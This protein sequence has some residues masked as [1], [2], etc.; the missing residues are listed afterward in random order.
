M[1]LLCKGSE[2]K[3]DFSAVLMC[4]MQSGGSPSAVHKAAGAAPGNLFR[5]VHSYDLPKPTGPKTLGVESV[6]CSLTSPPG[7]SEV[8]KHEPQG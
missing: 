2:E 8:G 1:P 3:I 4:V 7:N 5:D 6:I